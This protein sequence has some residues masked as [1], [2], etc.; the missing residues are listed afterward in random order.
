MARI[1]VVL[2]LCVAVSGCIPV[3]GSTLN[4]CIG[5]FHSTASTAIG[6][7]PDA[8]ETPAAA[9]PASPAALLDAGT[10]PTTD[11]EEAS[12]GR[13]P[14]EAHTD[15]A[16]QSPP[17]PA[18]PVPAPA[19]PSTEP[20]PAAPGAGAGAGDAP[21]A[22]P[23]DAA[24]TSE[25]DPGLAATLREA[26]GFCATPCRGPNGKV[27]I[28]YGH[29]LRITRADGDALLA[30]DIADARAAAERVV[31]AP[32]WNGLT[33]R[34]REVLTEMAYMAGPTGLARFEKMLAAVR[35][36]DYARAA[37]EITASLLRPPTRTVRLAHMMREG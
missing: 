20:T 28:G 9:I 5:C 6:E 36:G 13:A 25:S 1:I 31:G 15:G 24:P 33:E 18:N 12:P 35:A 7:A 29:A 27:H 30:Q 32:T 34:R 19:L 21:A 23:A 8:P 26:E 14:G 10:P 4:A 22:A 17:A 2:A 37:D 16:V 11:T 3:P